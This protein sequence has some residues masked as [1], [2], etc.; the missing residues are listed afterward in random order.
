MTNTVLD[1]ALTDT[2]IRL[3]PLPDEVVDLLRRLDAPPRL[4]AHLR[5][6]H[7]VADQL[8][9]LVTGRFPELA[10][11][12]PAVLYGAATHD[13]GKVIH[14]DELSGP[15]TAHEPAGEALLLAQGVPARLARF[16][17][18]HGSWIRT[19]ITVEDLLVSLADKIWKAKRVTDLET[20]VLDRIADT[21]GVQRWQAFLDLDDI[22]DRLAADADKRLA[23][24]GSYPIRTPR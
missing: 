20:L 7:D 15:G 22:L 13:I 16:A 12:R 17:G 23:Y 9:D 11:D 2:D 5:A 3:R 8:T 19:G 10:V 24:Q 14:I 21:A 1:N 4:A 18:S 6:V